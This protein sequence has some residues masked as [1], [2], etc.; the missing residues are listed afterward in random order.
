[1]FETVRDSV[2]SV[3]LTMLMLMFSYLS[4]LVKKDYKYSVLYR[5]PHFPIVHSCL[6]SLAGFFAGRSI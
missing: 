3:T 5:Q 6:R 2:N 1:M 4:F